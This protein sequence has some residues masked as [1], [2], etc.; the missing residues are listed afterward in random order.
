MGSNDGWV[1]GGS[2]TVMRSWLPFCLRV[3]ETSG[4]PVWRLLQRRVGGGQAL[5]PTVSLGMGVGE[6]SLLHSPQPLSPPHF[7]QVQLALDRSSPVTLQLF[8]ADRSLGSST[9]WDGCLPW[10]G[11]HCWR[12]GPHMADLA[13]SPQL[14]DPV[15]LAN[16]RKLGTCAPCRPMQP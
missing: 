7:P 10:A 13:L 3:R 8:W 15:L 6:Q 9:A 14:K 4:F 11:M 16:S 2:E 5:Y 12:A 1:W